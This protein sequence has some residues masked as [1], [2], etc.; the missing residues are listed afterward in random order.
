MRAWRGTPARHTSWRCVFLRVSCLVL[1]TFAGKR[2]EHFMFERSRI[3]VL[4]WHGFDLSDRLERGRSRG[5]VGVEGAVVTVRGE[6]TRFSGSEA[7]ANKA[8]GFVLGST[9]ET[10]RFTCTP[11]LGR[12]LDTSRRL[13]RPRPWGRRVVGKTA[14]CGPLEGS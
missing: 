9:F 8:S 5:R 10:E 13:Y 4:S 6:F 2:F 7:S 14:V 11:L 1:Q 3:T 12:S